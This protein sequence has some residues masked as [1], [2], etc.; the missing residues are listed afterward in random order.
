M[1]RAGKRRQR[2]QR[3]KKAS[4]APRLR[5]GNSQRELSAEGA[6]QWLIL[7][8]A[9]R[10]C[11]SKVFSKVLELVSKVLEFLPQLRRTTIFW[12]HRPPF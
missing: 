4:H 12:L 8:C 2:L 3:Q 7:R 1:V 10:Q 5:R 11:F 9:G 6:A